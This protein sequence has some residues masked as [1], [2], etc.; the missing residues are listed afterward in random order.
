MSI[1]QGATDN[2]DLYYYFNTPYFLEYRG[3]MSYVVPEDGI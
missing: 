2:N 3:D 1:L